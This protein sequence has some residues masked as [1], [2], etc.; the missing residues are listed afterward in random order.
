MVGIMNTETLNRWRPH[1]WVLVFG[2]IG[3]VLGLTPS[4]LPRTFFY[5]GLICGLAAASA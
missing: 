3:F 4:L 1:P 2:A 5:Q